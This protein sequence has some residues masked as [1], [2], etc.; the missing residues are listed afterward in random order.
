MFN[1]SVQTVCKLCVISLQTL[2][3]Q[4][5]NCVQ[6]V[7]Y[8]YDCL[9]LLKW[10]CFGSGQCGCL[11]RPI[12]WSYK[13][14]D[15]YSVMLSWHWFIYNFDSEQQQYF[16]EESTSRCCHYSH[17]TFSIHLHRWVP[18]PRLTR[19]EPMP[20]ARSRQSSSNPGPNTTLS[21]FP[22]HKSNSYC[23]TK[24]IK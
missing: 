14:V 20:R 9:C 22:S 13:C 15:D 6:T 16:V 7:F 8:P 12:P 11:E 19:A 18:G 21:H 4:C 1:Q 10:H 17:N 24:Y 23:N 3:K 2:C 5:A